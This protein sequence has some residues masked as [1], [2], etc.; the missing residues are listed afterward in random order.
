MQCQAIN[1][2]L[3]I[4]TGEFFGRL[5]NLLKLIGLQTAFL[6]TILWQRTIQDSNLE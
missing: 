1:G 6:L 3:S 4:S 5:C 2:A